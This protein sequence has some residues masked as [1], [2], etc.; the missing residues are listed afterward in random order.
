VVSGLEI[1][2]AVGIGSTIAGSVIG[3]KGYRK[4]AAAQRLA[5]KAEMMRAQAESESAKFEQQQREV[6]AQVAGIQGAREETVRRND[7]RKT[8]DNLSVMSA[9]RGGGGQSAQLIAERVSEEG[10]SDIAMAKYGYL[11]KGDLARR[12]AIMAGQRS[13]LALAQGSIAQQ[14]AEQQAGATELA[15]TA[16]LFS[17]IGKL[18]TMAIPRG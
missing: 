7:I 16:S 13:Q 6:E 14:A 18:G 4:T 3:Q 10:E 11:A 5:G 9:S 8:L 15:G 1:A 17:T 2:A 12:Q